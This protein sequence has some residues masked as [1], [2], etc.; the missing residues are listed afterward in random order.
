MSYCHFDNRDGNTGRHDVA[1][2]LASEDDAFCL[3]E[4]PQHLL[5]QALSVEAPL[6]NSLMADSPPHSSQCLLD[7]S[8]KK[9]SGWHALGVWSA[10]KSP[11]SDCDREKSLPPHFSALTTTFPQLGEYAYSLSS[12]AMLFPANRV[13]RCNGWIIEPVSCSKMQRD[14]QT[15][16]A[17]SSAQNWVFKT[18]NKPSANQAFFGHFAMIFDVKSSYKFLMHIQL[19]FPIV[20]RMSR[21]NQPVARDQQ[22]LWSLWIYLLIIVRQPT[23]VIINKVSYL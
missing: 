22:N 2:V 8:R 19:T 5:Y 14:L 10:G 17:E 16:R 1:A 12:D 6:P 21:V 11:F 15:S 18:V 9:E 23:S 7:S 3:A 4:A 13:L 20:G